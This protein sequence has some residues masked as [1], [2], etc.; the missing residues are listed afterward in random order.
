MRKIVLLLML[1]CGYLCGVA[2]PSFADPPQK[3]TLPYLKY[4]TLP[5]FNI[6]Q[7]D[8]VTIFNTFNIP[9]GRYSLL[10][11]F[12]PNCKH[13]QDV[14]REL[15]HGMDSISNIDFYFLTPSR[16]MDDIKAFYKYF[17]MADYKNIKQMGCDYEFFFIDYYGVKSF[18]DFALYDEKKN[19][20]Q[21]YQGRVTVKELWEATHH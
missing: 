21:L 14:T 5:A 10:V 6:R 11:L 16:S 17:R 12:E 13:C 7:M 18:P 8:S 4:P 1:C 3:D 19:F 2:Q 20:V 15:L 9:K